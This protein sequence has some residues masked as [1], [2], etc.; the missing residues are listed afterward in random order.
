MNTKIPS[1]WNR[2]TLK[3]KLSF[4]DND[5]PMT[6]NVGTQ[7]DQFSTSFQFWM[8]DVDDMRKDIT[9]IKHLLVKFESILVDNQVKQIEFLQRYFDRQTDQLRACQ[10]AF[11]LNVDRDEELRNTMQESADPWVGC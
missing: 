4:R 8:K 2:K 1:D 3:R 10:E 7:T 9:L 5:E 11:Q 6:A